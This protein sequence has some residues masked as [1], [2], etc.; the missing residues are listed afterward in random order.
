MKKILILTLMVLSNCSCSDQEDGTWDDNIKLFQK[1]FRVDASTNAVVI[2]TQGD[3]W[4]ITELFFREGQT[5][6]ISDTDTTAKNF[7][8]IASDFTLERKNGKEIIIEIFENTTNSERTFTAG[9]Q[10]GNYFDG[11]TITQSAD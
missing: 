4:W 8:I 9:L 6:D 1:E 10:A 11:I 2:T 5:F 7:K 3:S